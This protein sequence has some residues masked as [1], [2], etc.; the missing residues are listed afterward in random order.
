MRTLLPLLLVSLALTAQAA[1]A[2][3]APVR[4]ITVQGEV[5]IKAAAD[6]ADLTVTLYRE[7]KQAVKAKE[8]VD[9]LLVTLRSIIK[10][11]DIAE[12]DMRTQYTSIQPRYDYP[13]IGN[14]KP[15][16]EGYAAQHS[17]I[18]T[19]RD[20]DKLGAL[21]Q[22]MVERGIDRVDNIAYG[23]QKEGSLKEDALIQAIDVARR[24]AVRLAKAAGTEAAEV[25][26]IQESGTYIQP[27]QPIAIMRSE[28]AS[29]SSK[30]SAAPPV[31]DVEIR[32]SVTASYLLK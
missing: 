6:K 11:Y 9:R 12:K 2:Q 26:T 29:A 27:P 16:L 23:L 4:S 24:K 15:T 8:Q 14:G 5:V 30:V 22:A 7:A 25:L 13:A 3:Q 28:Y 18:I 31:G 19:L 17:I 21:M 20:I 32:S 1:D 10:E